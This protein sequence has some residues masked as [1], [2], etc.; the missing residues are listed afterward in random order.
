MVPSF[1]QSH[2]GLKWAKK[3]VDEI[4]VWAPSLESLAEQV[5]TIARRCERLNIILSR[6]KLHFGEEIDFAGLQ[7]SAS[8]IKPDPGQTEAL[9]KFPQPKDITGVRSFLGMAN[10]L[11][12][13]VPDFAH[14]SRHFIGLTGRNASFIWLPEHQSELK[15]MKHLLCSNL[16]VTHFDPDKDVTVLTD[17]SRLHGLGFVLGHMVN[18]QFKLVTCGSKALTP[19]Q[20]RYS[21]VELECLGVHYAVSKC[22]YYLKGLPSFTILT[23]HRPWKECSKRISLN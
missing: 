17:A 8:G 15:Q 22:S 7:I 14:M 18:N 5:R 12:G 2:K 13:F 4:L 23:D 1:R 19:T 20:Q 21:T 9:A 3:I 6:K 11:S 10:Q 16:V